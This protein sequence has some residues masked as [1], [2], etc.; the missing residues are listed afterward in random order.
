MRT[1][2]FAIALAL[3]WLP[4]STAVAQQPAA[5]DAEYAAQWAAAG[6]ARLEAEKLFNAGQ[7]GPDSETC[8]LM[9]SY[10]LHVVKAAAAAGAQ[11]RIV[12][13]TELTWQEQDAVKR[14]VKDV[15]ERNTRLR[16]VACTAKP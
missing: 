12:S 6:A 13:W 5:P 2:E 15:Y 7:R 8:R 3:A 4:A 16:A 11:T 10:F 14:K 9:D 1:R